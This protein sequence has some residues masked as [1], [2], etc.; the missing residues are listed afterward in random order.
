MTLKAPSIPIFTKLFTY[1]LKIHMA[2]TVLLFS[3][4]RW[5]ALRPYNG[6]DV[7]VRVPSV[8]I[9]EFEPDG[10]VSEPTDSQC[11]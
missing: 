9:R 1:S 10:C 11:H 7:E 2:L 6:V 8:V 3:E 5:E 4:G